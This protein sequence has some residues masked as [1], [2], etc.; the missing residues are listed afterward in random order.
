M[1]GL[2]RYQHGRYPEA[3]A[4]IGAAL[5]A[6]PNAPPALLNYAVVLDA[7]KRHSEALAGYDKA[8]AIRPDYAEAFCNRGIA[9]RELK[10][11]AE[12]L[13]SHD[14][15]LALKP[16]FAEAFY[17]RGIALRDLRRLG[18]ALESYDQALALKP[19]FPEA[20]NNRGVVLREL[21]RP[22]EALAS[23]DNALAIKPGYADALA[24]RGNALLDLK[25]LDEA[26]ENYDA[27]LA[28]KP[29]AAE[30]HFNRSM[31][32][33]LLGDFAGGWEEYEWRW[34]A[35]DFKSPRRN[36]TQPLWLG[37]QD[38][39]GRTI[40]L[41]GEQGLGDTLQFCRY[42]E[43]LAASGANVLME[44][45]PPLKSL[46]ADFAGVD[47]TLATGE[48]LP[49]FDFHCPLMSLPLALKTRPES[50][51]AKVPYLSAPEAHMQKWAARLPKA[52]P[53]RVGIA[54]AGNPTVATDPHR[55][56]GLPNMLPLLASTS[57]QF[58]SIQKD[59]RPGDSEILRAHPRIENLG[60]E[61][62][63]F[64][65][66]AA[67][68]S[69][70]DLIISSDTSVVHLAGALGKP[71][72][73]LLAYVPDFRWLLDRDDSPWYPTVR[74]FRQPQIDDWQSV[75]SQVRD[76]LERLQQAR[77]RD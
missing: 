49:A 37:D 31:L 63:S 20:L 18:E 2:L 8:L 34:K 59:L 45:Q 4:L 73:I 17:N 42:E 22:A 36:F 64:A 39:N 66:T 41:H 53:L 15:A 21:M 57:V 11:P 3:L 6:D 13:A 70:L 74:L 67:I 28:L 55:S 1:L 43:M 14:R 65:D 38:L 7:L 50:I 68:M 24:N 25:R 32:R 56:I 40:L 69:H 52:G 26:R 12:A 19:D 51:P 62:E 30:T 5:R 23:Y 35:R 10:R 72:W 54:W 47:R 27:A 58:V 16:A 76:E 77:A 46:F 9:L 33:L 48:P 71:V 29:E 75:I 60:G 61:I 44:V